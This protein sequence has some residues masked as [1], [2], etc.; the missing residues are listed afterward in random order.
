MMGESVSASAV[1]AVS[2]IAVTRGVVL[3]IILIALLLV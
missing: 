2:S 1:T 3:E